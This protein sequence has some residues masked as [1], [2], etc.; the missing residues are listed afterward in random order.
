MSPD[1]R[2]RLVKVLKRLSQPSSMAGFAS[3]AVVAHVSAPQFAALTDTVA[4]AAG[5]LAVW[6][7][8]GSNASPPV[9]GN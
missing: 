7:D 5:L 9:E 6:F 1:T 3:L 2:N 4:I 8:D